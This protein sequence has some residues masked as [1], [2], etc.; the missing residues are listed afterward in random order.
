MSGR[1][2]LVRT[3]LVASWSFIVLGV[4]WLR[5]GPYYDRL[6]VDAANAMLP[7]DLWLDVLGDAI[8]INHAADAGRF[9]H[10]IDALV[11]HSGV[12]IVLA[13]ASATPARSWAWRIAAGVALTGGFLALQSIAMAVFAR[14]LKDSL[15][16]A[17]L[18][19]D[20]LIGFAIFWALTPLA[21]GGVWVYRFWLPALLRDQRDAAAAGPGAGPT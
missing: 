14:S 15:S 16:G 3:G 9:R 20:V 8:T 21:V 2:S 1:P 13:L 19:G 10:G 18:A 17:V 12:V 4:V 5:V 7:P 6:L 11:L